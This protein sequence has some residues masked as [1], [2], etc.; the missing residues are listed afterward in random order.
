ADDLDF[1][2]NLND[3]GLDAAGDDGAATRDREHVLD[4]HHE[5][6]VERTLGLRDVLVDL[7]HQLEH[8]F[9]AE[10]VVRA[11]ERAGGRTLDDLVHE[12]HH[13]RHADLA[14]EQD[15]LAGLRHRA[16]GGR[17]DQD[18]AVHL[19]CAGD[20]VL[21]IVGVA[22][23]IDVRI[24]AVGRLI[25]DVGGRDGDAALAL[26]GSLVDVREV[27]GGAAGGLCENLG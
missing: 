13:G 9:L 16:V 2:T 6:L 11:R 23:A 5:R 12:H 4:R 8:G 18:R 22:G 1:L 21:H 3:A 20:H 17:H 15:V 25:L 24:V 27:N 14:G 10:R 26:L 7:L 19:G